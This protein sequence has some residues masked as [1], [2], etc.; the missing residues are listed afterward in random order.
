ME[1]QERIVAELDKINQVIVDCREL[2]RNLDSLALSLFY[3]TFGDPVPNPKGW[4]VAQLGNYVQLKN[5]LNF[6][7]KD[8]GIQIKCLSVS[9]FK[10][11]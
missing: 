1:E 11:A 9:D 5:G 8:N 4:D 2:L 7:P 10:A 6:T 3:D